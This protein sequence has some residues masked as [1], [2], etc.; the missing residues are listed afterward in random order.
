MNHSSFNA[1]LLLYLHTYGN[2]LL[3]LFKY[4][5]LLFWFKFT[6]KFLQVILQNDSKTAEVLIESQIFFA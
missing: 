5:H 4:F 1:N 2:S 6:K 3:F